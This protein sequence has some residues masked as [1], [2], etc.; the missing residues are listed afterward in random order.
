MA[1]DLT[2]DEKSCLR[3]IDRSLRQDYAKFQNLELILRKTNAALV[4][5]AILRRNHRQFNDENLELK[6]LLRHYIQVKLPH[7]L[8]IKSRKHLCNYTQ[9]ILCH[10]IKVTFALLHP[11]NIVFNILFDKTIY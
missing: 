1:S 5:R 9:H 3:R 7:Y 4:D 6:E 10:F 8:Q 11:G 2:D